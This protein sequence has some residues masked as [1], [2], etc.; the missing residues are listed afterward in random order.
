MALSAR[1]RE[2]SAAIA[3]R[4]L[5]DALAAYP[6]DSAAAFERQQDRFA[7]PVGHAL[8]VATR[9]A[10]EALAQGR[11]PGEICRHL[12]EVVKIRAIQEFKPS[13]ALCFVFMLKEAVAPNW[14][15]KIPG[16]P[17]SRV[18]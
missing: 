5:A 3:Q 7:N 10:V 12:D 6:A 2:K 4:W 9:T 15:R 13:E 17:L 18:G 8:R 14:D 11:E 16:K 1:M